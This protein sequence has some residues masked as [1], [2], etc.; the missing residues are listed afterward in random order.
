MNDYFEPMGDEKPE[1]APTA[2]EMDPSEFEPLYP[3]PN[4]QEEGEDDDE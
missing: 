2:A 3:F 1:I 4:G